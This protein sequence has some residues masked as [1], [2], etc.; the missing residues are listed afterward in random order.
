MPSPDANSPPLI[1]TCSVDAV[2]EALVAFTN[3]PVADQILMCHGARLD[4]AKPLSAYKLPLVRCVALRACAR[5]ASGLALSG[6]CPVS[7]D[8][9]TN[10]Q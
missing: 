7:L 10:Q 5:A 2:Q 4:P 8:H 6:C 1:Y 9:S 3:V